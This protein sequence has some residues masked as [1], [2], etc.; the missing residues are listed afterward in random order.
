MKETR[1]DRASKLLDR[2]NRGPSWPMGTWPMGMTKL[3]QREASRI[4]RIWAETWIIPEVRALIPEL[5]KAAR[6]AAQNAPGTHGRPQDG[7]GAA[8]GTTSHS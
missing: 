6:Q 8:E 1:K 5:S 3:A 2:L 4:F 7:S